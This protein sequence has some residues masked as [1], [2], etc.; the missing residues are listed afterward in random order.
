MIMPNPIHPQLDL[1][2]AMTDGLELAARELMRAAQ[3]QYPRTRRRVGATLRPGP[4]A[5][6]WGALA[7]AA[8]PYLKKYGEQAQLARLLG[9]DASR[10]HEYF[11][12]SA[13]MP[14]AERTLLL[15]QWLALRRAGSR[16]G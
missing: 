8:R 7:E 5:P 9:V 16:P 10:V 14:D 6:L 11:I 2:F 1:I 12:S 15:L 13:A 3:R 4:G